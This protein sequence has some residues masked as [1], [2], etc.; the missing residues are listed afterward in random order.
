MANS[1]C[2]CLIQQ[3][4]REINLLRTVYDLFAVN[5][6]FQLFLFLVGFTASQQKKI[7]AANLLILMELFCMK[8]ISFLSQLFQVN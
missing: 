3:T 4:S 2:L 1:K 7:M 8:Y 5:L 6:D